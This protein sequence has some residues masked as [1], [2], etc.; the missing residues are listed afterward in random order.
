MPSVHKPVLLKEV[1]EYLNPA[2]G[3]NFIDCTFG[4]GGHS[5]EILK[6]I[7]PEGKLL[8]I[9]TDI[10]TSNQISDI[11]NNK[12]IIF[13]NDNFR[14]LKRIVAEN[15]PYPAHGILLDLGLSSDQLE[16]SGRGFSFFKG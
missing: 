5:W 12:S 14:N 8:A 11:R 10:K 16:T 1:L 9:D 2:P 4:D 6:R 7:G 13:I 3:K 15:F